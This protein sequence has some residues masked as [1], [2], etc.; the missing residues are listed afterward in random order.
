MTVHISLS[1]LVGSPHAVS[2]ADGTFVYDRIADGLRRGESVILSFAGVEDVTSAFLNAAVGQLY[3]E[4]GEHQIREKLRV[5]DADGDHLALLK[6]VVERA[7]EF[8]RD[9]EHYNEAFS[10]AL[11]E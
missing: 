4:F 5:E 11:N 8:F 6:R 3:A 10:G 1:E 7:K 9:A 2:S